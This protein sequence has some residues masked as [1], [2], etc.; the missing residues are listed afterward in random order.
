MNDVITPCL[1]E[2][3]VTVKDRF[4]PIPGGHNNFI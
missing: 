4:L 1:P 3:K 2:Q